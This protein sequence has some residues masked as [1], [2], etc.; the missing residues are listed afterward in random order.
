MGRGTMDETALATA[1]Y[2]GGQI[3]IIL[4]FFMSDIFLYLSNATHHSQH[5]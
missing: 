4:I 5:T 3:L 1:T 2:E